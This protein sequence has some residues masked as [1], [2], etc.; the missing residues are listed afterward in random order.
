MVSGGIGIDSLWQR[1]R[2][3]NGMATKKHATFELFVS[4]NGDLQEIYGRALPGHTSIYIQITTC[5]GCHD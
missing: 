5:A 3:R 1:R 2:V 4:K